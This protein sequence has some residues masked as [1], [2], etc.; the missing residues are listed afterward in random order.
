MTSR[1]L[2]VLL[3]LALLIVIG[4]L[5]A[6]DT[7]QP[8]S[9]Y[10]LT[11][12]VAEHGSIDLAPYAHRLGVDHA[13]YNG[14]LRSDKGPGQP[15]FAVPFYLAGRALGAE[16][17]VHAR[18]SGDLGLWWN[19]LWTSTIPFLVLVAL[20][21]LFAERFARPDA[22][23]AVAL[24]IG[25]CTMML[26]LAVNLYAHSL[27][28][29]LTYGAWMLV[30]DTPVSA[31][32]AAL[33]GVCAGAAVLTEYETGIGLIVLAGYL[34]VRQRDRLA[35]FAL[36]A[37]A[38]LGLLAW[39]QWAAF[40]APWHTPSSYYAG[41]INGTSEGGYAIPGLHNLVSVVFGNRGLVVGAPIALVGLVAA[42]MLAI[43]GTGRTRWHGVVALAIT[44]PYLALCAGWSGLAILEEPG[45]RYLIPALPFLAVP[46]AVLWERL[47]RPAALAAIVGAAI[48]VPAATTFILLRIK[49][50]PYPEY[51]NRIRDH[52]FLPT[53][54]SMAAGR[55]GVV[56]YACSVVLAVGGYA[57]VWQRA[58]RADGRGVAVAGSL[59]S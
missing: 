53:L 24:I 35:W 28:A 42:T 25:L 14:H 22:A 57:R 17:A 1:R 58:R 32:W 3:G 8:A 41:T 13:I 31:R 10:S 23:L 4:P 54:W 6:R 43:S 19:S 48:S 21:Y 51:L 40:G 29:L 45:P 20:M 7:A 2:A 33:A 12:A 36:G 52:Q 59:A 50:P 30:E 38:P 18:E 37:A 49:Q 56:L 16:S 15:F 11:A 46:L 27:S 5:V 55:L 34:I 44:I 9:R 47:W 39:Y 26:P